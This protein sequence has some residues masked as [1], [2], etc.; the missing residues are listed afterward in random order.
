MSGLGSG[1]SAFKFFPAESLGGVGSLKALSGPFP[2]VRFCPTGGVTLKNLPD[3]L[4]LPNVICAGGSW[5]IPPNLAE[6]GAFDKVTATARDAV[7]LAKA[8]RP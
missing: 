1:L 7:A 8:S 3:Y 6:T 2:Q 5:M 4:A